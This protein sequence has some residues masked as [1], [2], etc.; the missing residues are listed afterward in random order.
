MLKTAILDLWQ[1]K[2]NQQHPVNGRKYLNKTALDVPE[3]A[4]MLMVTPGMPYLDVIQQS[5]DFSPLPSGTYH[6]SWEYTMIKAA[7]EKG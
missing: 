3:G 2:P 4:G 7:C 6:V 5:K 1:K